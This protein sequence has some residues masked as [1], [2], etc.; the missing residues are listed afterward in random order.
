MGMCYQD[1]RIKQ[2][3]TVKGRRV[4]RG[5]CLCRGVCVLGTPN[6]G[7]RKTVVKF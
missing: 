1:E 7:G 5:W 4:A 2:P 3:S 6:P